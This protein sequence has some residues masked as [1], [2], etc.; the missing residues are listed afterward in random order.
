METQ[1]Q[2]GLA[3]EE[4]PEQTLSVDVLPADADNNTRFNAFHKRNPHVYLAIVAIARHL[5]QEGWK[6]AGMKMIFERLRWKYAMKTRGDKWNFN[7]TYTA[8]YA[9]LVMAQE[10]DLAGFFETREKKIT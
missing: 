9:R 10:K 6:K 2:L 7:N 5:K 3:F 4:S 1:H 8:H